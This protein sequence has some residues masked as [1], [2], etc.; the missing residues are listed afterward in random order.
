M[1]IAQ[2]VA[3]HHQAVYGYAYRLTGKVADAEDLTQQVF[4]TAQVKLG[5]VRNIESVRSWLFAILRH[6]FVKTIVKRR[7]ILAGS[8]DLNV[9]DL[10]VEAPAAEDIDREALQQALNE[11]PPAYRAVVTMFYY[12]NRSYREI[13]ESLEVPIGTVMSRLARA[14]AHLR[15]V[16]AGRDGACDG[17]PVP[18]KTTTRG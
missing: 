8:I 14:K 3:E 9:N 6:R 7:P 11:L 16:L 4:L 12:E 13:A 15:S 18:R 10:P 17:R 2:L 5:Q 1:D